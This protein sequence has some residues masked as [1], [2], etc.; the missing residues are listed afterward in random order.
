M[1]DFFANN[2]EASFAFNVLRLLFI[3]IDIGL[4]VALVYVLSNLWK[5]RPPLYLDL[6]PGRRVYT[7]GHAVIKER[8]EKVTRKFALGTPEGLALA[9]IEADKVVDD[10][11]KSLGLEGQ[12]MADRLGQLSPDELK[13]FSRVWRAHRLRNEVVHSPDFYLTSADAERALDDF[14]SFLKEVQALP[15]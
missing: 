6:E 9:L 13:T 5:L 8:W 15:E 11:L 14:E 4:F 12:H 2:P 10:V 1:P 3:I 7:L